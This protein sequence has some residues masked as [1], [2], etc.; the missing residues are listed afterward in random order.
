MMRPLLN[1]TLSLALA[2]VAAAQ[3]DVTAYT[4]ARILAGGRP[5]M[6]GAT[7]IVAGGKIITL[8]SRQALLYRPKGVSMLESTRAWL[9]PPGTQLTQKADGWWHDSLTHPALRRKVVAENAR[10]LCAAL[11][12]RLFGRGPPP[13]RFVPSAAL[14]RA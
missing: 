1:C 14:R 2:A 8:D 9:L 3:Q 13:P 12:S 6:T 10:A 7:M 5:V 11:V 4:N